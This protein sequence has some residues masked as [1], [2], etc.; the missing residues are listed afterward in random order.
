MNNPQWVNDFHQ[1]YFNSEPEKRNQGYRLLKQNRPD[2]FCRYIGN[3][4]YIDSYLGSLSQW[5][6]SPKKFEDKFDGRWY[7]FSFDSERYNPEEIELLNFFGEN[8]EHC[9]KEE[10]DED[11]SDILRFIL[12]LC[13]FTT[14][15]LSLD[16]WENYA[17]N[18]QGICVEYDISKRNYFKPTGI[19]NSLYPMIYTDEPCDLSDYILDYNNPGW[20]K[21]GMFLKYLGILKALLKSSKYKEE[22]EWRSITYNPVCNG[23]DIHTI[24][25]NIYLGVNSPEE[26]REQVM[27]TAKNKHFSVYQ[28]VEGEDIGF[29]PLF[30]P[31]PFF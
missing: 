4:G 22:K 2:K 28:V 24:P 23:H 31:K 15:P 7:K 21:D 13:S 25:T 27:Q 14:N 20:G 8:V 19:K 26:I 18:S 5:Y 10:S 12:K 30:E 11:D 17:E 6:E 16:M 3:P 9:E 1:L 29:I